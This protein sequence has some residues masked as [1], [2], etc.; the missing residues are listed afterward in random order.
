[1]KFTSPDGEWAVESVCL[2]GP[3]RADKRACL[4]A[5][6]AEH[7][8]VTRFGF[9][10]ANVPCPRI[11]QADGPDLLDLGPLAEVLPKEVLSL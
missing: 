10:V 2:D 8:A 5:A 1:M 9:L 11:R 7:L 6:P 4:P 3:V